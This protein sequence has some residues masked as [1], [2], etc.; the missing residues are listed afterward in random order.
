MLHIIWYVYFYNI[1]LIYKKNWFGIFN[2]IY[3]NKMSDA[4][5]SVNSDYVILGHTGTYYETYGGGGEGG[6]FFTNNKWYSV[7][8]NWNVPWT[9]KKCPPMTF[10]PED[11]RN[12]IGAEIC[13]T[14]TEI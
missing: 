10:T 4:V 2:P 8:R 3:N 1:W 12:G 7:D 5:Y 11:R 6:F 14:Y 9:M 13:E